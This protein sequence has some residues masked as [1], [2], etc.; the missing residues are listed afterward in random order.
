VPGPLYQP[1]LAHGLQGSLQAMALNFQAAGEALG[2]PE[3]TIFQQMADFF[4]GLST[5]EIAAALAVASQNIAGGQAFGTQGAYAR[6]NL[7][8][9]PIC[10]GCPP[11]RIETEIRV[12]ISDPT[13]G[14]RELST[15]VVRAIWDHVPTEEELK[16]LS[17][18]FA[19]MLAGF[20]AGIGH[21][22][23]AYSVASAQRGT[24]FGR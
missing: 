22:D 6:P 9:I 5:D 19:E 21:Y 24:F 13:T 10:A 2:L 15:G 4:P 7:S 1:E 12:T 14:A 8:S 11:N 3:G 17:D 16:Q 20:Y 18:E 23:T